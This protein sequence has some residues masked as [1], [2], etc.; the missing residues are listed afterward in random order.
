MVILEICQKNKK[1]CAVWIEWNGTVT[2]SRAQPGDIDQRQE[3]E[4]QG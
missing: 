3:T 4:K 2:E 1:S